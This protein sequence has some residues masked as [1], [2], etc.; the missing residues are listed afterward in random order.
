MAVNSV[1]DV[2]KAFMETLV[3][4]VLPRSMLNE[5]PSDAAQKSVAKQMHA[6]VLLYNYYH[7]KQT[8]GL[9]FLSFRTF[10]R[11][12]ESL[13]PS[14]SL[15]MKFSK[16]NAP[17]DLSNTDNQL[18]VTEKAITDACRI[19][20]SLDASKDV[21]V[22]E[23][24]PIL[25]VAVLLIDSKKENCYLK[26]GAVTDGVWS[27]VEKEINESNISLDIL[28]E[29]KGRKKRRTDNG[30]SNCDDKFLQLAYEAV[31]DVTS[32]SSS[33]L[34]IL[35]D[36]VVRSLSKE[37]SSAHFFMMQ[38]SQTFDIRQSVS[39]KELV[40]SL[41]GPLAEKN[42]DSWSTT[43]VVE[44]HHLLPYVGLISSWLSRKDLRPPLLNGDNAQSGRKDLGQ[45]DINWSGKKSGSA[46]KVGNENSENYQNKRKHS[47]AGEIAS[48]VDVVQSTEEHGNVIDGF[49]DIRDLLSDKKGSRINFAKSD[50]NGET[51]ERG[52]ISDPSKG[53]SRSMV[54]DN[55]EMKIRNVSGRTRSRKDGT[56]PTPTLT[57]KPASKR[58]RKKSAPSPQHGSCGPEDGDNLMVETEEPSK[59]SD[60]LCRDEKMN[61]DNGDTDIS[62]NQNRIAANE[63]PLAESETL[64]NIG[65]ENATA[66]ADPLKPNGGLRRDERMTA[67]N[68]DTN[69]P[70]NKNGI[71][72]KKNP[73]SKSEAL[74]KNGVVNGMLSAT[75][76]SVVALLDR[77]SQARSSEA[78][79]TLEMQV[80]CEYLAARIRRGGE[81][82][83]ASRCLS[84]I[85]SGNLHLLLNEVQVLLDKGRRSQTK[86]RLLLPGKSSCQ[87]LELICHSNILSLP[88]YASFPSDVH[89]DK[90][91]AEVTVQIDGAILHA[92]S[93]PESSPDEAREASAAKMISIISDSYA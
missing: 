49:N 14:M 38:Y 90:F 72:A 27:L 19:A 74:Q 79:R 70:R 41:Q 16:D 81:F 20:A 17:V 57:P 75:E 63:N 61:A 37:K 6:V 78:R 2:V 35:E 42:D 45:V 91:R 39:L 85:I 53:L 26:F 76:T 4:P 83:L 62:P 55:N 67:D 51:L 34:V 73:P 58:G 11:V 12:A 59:S 80:A 3:D 82:D 29:Q 68:G 92:L 52:Y 22:T 8:Q 10:C 66:S 47:P 23:G 87:D 65:V 1:K 71:S 30:T 21:P 60:S 69:I 36:H 56:S 48:T 25:K 54:R 24:C 46:D 44:F 89:P 32:I 5:A 31:K 13:R 28:A 64:N 40:E 33:D 18:S 93:D 43:K 86:T 77:E 50:N 84:H 15:F 9:E 7:M 88:R